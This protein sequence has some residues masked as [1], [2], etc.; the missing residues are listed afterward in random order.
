MRTDLDVKQM[1]E[2]A[3]KDITMAVISILHMFN[4]IEENLNMMRREKGNIKR[5]QSN[6]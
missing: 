3:D 2:L 4:E 5:T 1:I 6:F